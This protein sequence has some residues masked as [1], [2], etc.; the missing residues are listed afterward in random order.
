MAENQSVNGAIWNDQ[1][2]KL[3]TRFG[4]EQV[5]DSEIDVP[6][7]DGK[8]RGIDRV[9]K[10][11]DNRRNARRARTVFVEAKR[12]DVANISQALLDDWLETLNTKLTKTRNSLDF[13]DKYPSL[14]ETDI[15]SGLIT[16]WFH[17][18]D[19]DYEKFRPKFLKMLEAAKLPNP[20]WK[21]TP[22][23]I[24]VIEKYD[25]LRLASLLTSVENYEREKA[26]EVKFH[27]PHSENFGNA[28]SRNRV[29]SLDFMFSKVIFAEAVVRGVTELL[30][31]YFGA[32]SV[33]AF[34]RLRS[35]LN[36]VGFIDRDK[37]LTI[38][39]YT[40]DDNFRTIEPEVRKLFEGVEL[41]LAEMEYFSRLPVFMRDTQ[42]G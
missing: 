7:E 12:Y 34:T 42:N 31:F 6:T 29:L 22:N 39:R 33:D 19:A 13:L 10:Y 1:M 35:L 16:I 30:V 32:L 20:K 23:N 11:L 3:L 28:V 2:A 37:P 18:S 27:Y 15:R 5:G 4:W 26:T 38:Y 8:D 36:D 40:E 24:Y 9:F 21:Q 41:R 14:K 25:I 17:S